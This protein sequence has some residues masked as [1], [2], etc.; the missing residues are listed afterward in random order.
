MNGC[1]PRIG[2]ISSFNPNTGTAMIYYPDRCGEVTD[3]LPVY[4]PCGLIQEF[5]KDDAV[6]VLHFSNGSEAGIVLGK[7]T[8]GPSGAGIIVSG[9]KMVLKDSSGIISLEKIIERCK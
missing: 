5:Q 7:Y 4:M 3:E 6:L 9:D 2:F 8:L 1:G